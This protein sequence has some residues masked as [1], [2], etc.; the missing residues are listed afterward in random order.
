[1]IEINLDASLEEVT[2]IYDGDGKRKAL[3]SACEPTVKHKLV[4]VT[5]DG[6]F[7]HKNYM[8]YLENCYDRH[9]GYVIS[10][11]MVW[12]TLLSELA[13]HIKNNAEH[14]RDLFTDSDEKKEI[15]VEG[16]VSHIDEILCR[17]CG[18]CLDACPYGAIE[19]V[20]REGGNTVS[21]VRPALCKGCGSSAVACPNGAASIFH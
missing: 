14:Y 7:Y 17:G 15:S 2:R 20:E 3:L 10:P 11:D 19:L 13:I 5:V 1:M 16:V 12:Y 21:R 6:D 18:R 8:E 9:Y 4:D